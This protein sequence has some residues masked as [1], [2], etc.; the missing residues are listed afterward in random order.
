MPS[1]ASICDPDVP[2]CDQCLI[3]IMQAYARHLHDGNM[4]LSGQQSSKAAQ[5]HSSRHTTMLTSE[6]TLY[7]GNMNLTG[8][9]TTTAADIQLC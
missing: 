2:S 3:A 4:N 9:Q 6:G 7:Q 5:Q 1:L 8:Q